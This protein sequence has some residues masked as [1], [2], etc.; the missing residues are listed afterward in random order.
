LVK[1]ERAQY[2]TDL[3][4][5]RG[6]LACTVMLYH[7]GLDTIVRR[8]T[9]GLIERGLWGASVDF[10]FLLSGFVLYYS[11]ERSRPT[12]ASYFDKR[13]RRLA[14]MYLLTTIVMMV[15]ALRP[16][17]VSDAIANLLMVQSYFGI[18]TINRP[19]WSIPYE[20]FL[21]VVLLPA[22]RILRAASA[23]RMAW[24]LALLI[25]CGGALIVF[26]ALGTDPLSVRAIL[27]LGC[28]V[29]LGQVHQA[30]A[31]ATPR[32]ILVLFLFGTT[33]AIITLA[34]ELPFT[35]AFF[36]LAAT[37]S[38]YFGAQ[39]Q[40]ILSS[41]PLRA[42]GRWSYSIYL[43]HIPVLGTASA[44]VVAGDESIVF[45][46]SVVFVTIALAAFCFRFI[47][48]PAMEALRRGKSGIAVPPP[49]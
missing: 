1:K 34:I 29:V 48:M 39:T 20:L 45:K 9:A 37:A 43:L 6:V 7:L 13:I 4:G 33:V 28:G 18:F 31:P 15:L 19:A 2:F 38:I 26:C 41:A 35:A 21:P 40:T 32:P 27:G 30:N 3:D 24:I 25:V 46:G 12:V 44:L 36:Y 22:A 23:R 8:F 14:P 17:T 42:L 49:A 16:Y 47:E 5:M 11:I 10:F